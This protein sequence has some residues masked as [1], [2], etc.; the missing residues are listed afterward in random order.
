[1]NLIARLRKLL[2]GT[3]G[4]DLLE[5]A[6]LVALIALICVAVITSS[7]ASVKQISRAFQ[8][9]SRRLLPPSSLMS[10]QCSRHLERHAVIAKEFACAHDLTS[11]QRTSR[12]RGNAPPGSGDGQHQVTE[13]AAGLRRGRKPV[14]WNRIHHGKRG[15]R[16]RA[17]SGR[18]P[19]RQIVG[20][21]ERVGGVH[22]AAVLGRTVEALLRRGHE[23]DR[24]C[25]RMVVGKS[26]GPTK[27]SRRTACARFRR[28]P[29]HRSRPRSC[30]RACSPR[31]SIA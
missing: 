29:D 6:L 23:A 18:R 2:R 5:Y 15:Q 30:R 19:A 13:R 3:A 25:G 8:V 24:A 7:G 11:N 21:Q 16:P 14:R 28:S 20:G 12:H 10:W 26:R 9:N 31:V 27:V 1:M 17:L 4:Q 22:A